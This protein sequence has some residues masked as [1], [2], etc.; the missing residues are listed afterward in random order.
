M[1]VKELTTN[2]LLFAIIV[3]MATVPQLGFVSLFGVPLTLLHL[4]VLLGA[5]WFPKYAWTYGLVFG[6]SSWAVA[7]VRPVTPVDLLFQ[8]PLVSVAPRLVFG[9]LIPV[10]FQLISTFKLNKLV[11]MA[12]TAFVMTMVHAVLVLSMVAVFGL[13]LLGG[14]QVALGVIGGILLTNSVPEA[15]LAVLVVT[16][17]IRRLHA[18]FD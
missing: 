18:L 15:I 5:F 7:L 16:P 14:S 13:D 3:I 2:A 8:N 17:I 12:T 1:K 9:L 6:L 11:A 4:P 10:V